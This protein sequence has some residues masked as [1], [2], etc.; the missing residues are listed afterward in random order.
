VT[1]LALHFD[2]TTWRAVPT[3]NPVTNSTLDQ[4]VLLSVKAISA[5]DVTA[6]GFILDSVQQ[7]ELTLVEHWNGVQ[8]SVSESPNISADSGSLNTLT[9]ISGSSSN[10]LYAVGFF[11]NS[12]TA[13]QPETMVEHFDG[14]TWSIVSSPTRGFAQ[15]LNG[16][17]ALP[18]S[19][20]VWTVGAFSQFGADPETG[21]LQVPRTLVLF[22]PIG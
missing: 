4:N 10:D 14:S 8:W 1:T 11:G 18:N 5:T 19:N 20:N 13:G 15:H 3:P 21:L 16:V 7:R 22:T 6:A 2:G 12:S 9:G 17:F